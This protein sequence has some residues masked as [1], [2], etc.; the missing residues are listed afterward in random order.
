MIFSKI[1]EALSLISIMIDH[2]KD[3]KELAFLFDWMKIARKPNQTLRQDIKMLFDL[4]NIPASD[5][6]IHII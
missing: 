5:S 3:G 6:E 4:I 2:S 1:L